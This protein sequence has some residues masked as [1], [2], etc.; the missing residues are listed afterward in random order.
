VDD[1]RFDAAFAEAV[2][3]SSPFPMTVVRQRADGAVEVVAINA[4]AAEVTGWDLERVRGRTLEDLYPADHAAR[5]R[6][7]LEELG[8]PGSVVEYRVEGEVASGRRAYEV[9]L[10]SLGEHDGRRL[11][12]T[13]SHDVT[14]REVAEAALEDTQR[15]AH[16]GHFSWNVETGEITW[17]PQMYEL[18]G[19]PQGSAVT[20]ERVLELLED[21]A[22]L[23]AAIDEVVERGGSYEIELAVIRPDG[24]RRL[25]MARGRGVPGRD[26]DTVRVTGTTQD[27]TEQRAAETDAARFSQARA[28]QAQALDLNDDILQGL[29]TVRI[30]LMQDEHELAMDVLDRT[31]ESAREIISELLREHLGT[32]PVPGDLVRG[33]SR[34]R[35]DG[36]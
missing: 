9:R 19:L 18:F 28:K 1:V 14:R 20:F 13:F 26:G 2:F 17:T 33:A 3:R 5:T 31:L 10:V 6:G 12:V 35:G 15:L 29:A 24:E 36:G 32:G 25:A 8:G 4:R 11:A 16:I 30:A 27:I 22:P 7:F 21:A 23:Q 34:R